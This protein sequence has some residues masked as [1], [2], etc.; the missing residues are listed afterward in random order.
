M[1]T[2][3]VTALSLGVLISGCAMQPLTPTPE[4]ARAAQIVVGQSRADVENLMRRPGRIVVYPL[5]P[6]E[7]VQI[8]RY[9]D[10]FSSRCLF[11]TYDASGRVKEAANFER[12]RDERGKFGTRF[13]GSC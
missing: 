5:K 8:W 3:C 10:H 4:A 2:T 12:E 11:V 13:S 7:T 9:E 1:K 6:D